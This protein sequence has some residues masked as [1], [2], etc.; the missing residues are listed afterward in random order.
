MDLLSGNA[1]RR[2]L[3][4]TTNSTESALNSVVTGPARD[5]QISIPNLYFSRSINPFTNHR[6]ISSTTRIGGS[7]TSREPAMAT[8][9]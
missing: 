7:I 8:F 3:T 4:D 2:N 1:L 9:Q 5:P 6:C